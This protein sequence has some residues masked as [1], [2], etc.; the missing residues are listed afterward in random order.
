[1]NDDLKRVP[2]TACAEIKRGQP[3]IYYSAARGEVYSHGAE[4]VVPL[5]DEPQEK[6]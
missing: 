4:Q 6:K 5:T 2:D 1:M 3:E